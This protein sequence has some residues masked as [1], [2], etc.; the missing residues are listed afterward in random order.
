M[1]FQAEFAYYKKVVLGG[2]PLM[3]VVNAT[4]THYTLVECSDDNVPYS[5]GLLRVASGGTPVIMF[6]KADVIQD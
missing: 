1:G 3:A 2:K 5:E 4:S 6:G